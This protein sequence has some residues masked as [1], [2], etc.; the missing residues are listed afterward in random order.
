MRD[1]GTSKHSWSPIAA[2]M[3]PID[4]AVRKGLAPWSRRDVGVSLMMLIVAAAA[5]AFGNPF[6]PLTSI[7]TRTLVLLPLR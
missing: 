6:P 1:T 2:A 3:G 5:M 4:L 7:L